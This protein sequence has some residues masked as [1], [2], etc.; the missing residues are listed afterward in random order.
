MPPSRL[1][2]SGAGSLLVVV[3]VTRVVGEDGVGEAVAEKTVLIVPADQRG[4]LVEVGVALV[5]SGTGPENPHGLFV[6]LE[7]V[8]RARLQPAIPALPSLEDDELA[9]SGELEAG[10]GGFVHEDDLLVLR[11]ELSGVVEVKPDVRLAIGRAD[12]AVHL[13]FADV[14]ELHRSEVDCQGAPLSTHSHPVWI[15][16]LATPHVR[17]VDGSQVSPL[18]ECP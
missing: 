15:L 8:P 5:L 3:T 1:R 6:L 14:E 12:E 7:G 10:R 11:L 16:I 18:F 13:V 17:S 9:D 4:L 2:F